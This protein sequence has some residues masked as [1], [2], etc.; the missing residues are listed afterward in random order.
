MKSAPSA[1]RAHLAK[2]GRAE[3]QTPFEPQRGPHATGPMIRRAGAVAYVRVLPG[4]AGIDR[5]HAGLSSCAI[6]LL[7]RRLPH[8]QSHSGGEGRGSSLEPILQR[9]PAVRPSGVMLR[10]A[11]R[12]HGLFPKTWTGGD[13][14]RV[15][16]P[17]GRH[18]LPKVPQGGLTTA[19]GAPGGLLPPRGGRTEA[20]LLK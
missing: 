18:S 19:R 4:L 10:Q 5:D 3:R 8:D 6:S 17:P 15:G 13:R 14:L 11:R 20:I 1:L 16:A 2:V 9:F 7:A 12:I